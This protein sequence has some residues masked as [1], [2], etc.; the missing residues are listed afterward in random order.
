[1][2]PALVNHAAPALNN[3]K[4]EQFEK[5]KLQRVRCMLNHRVNQLEFET[6]GGAWYHVSY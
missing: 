2:A 1:M 5:I 3:S 4:T 6:V